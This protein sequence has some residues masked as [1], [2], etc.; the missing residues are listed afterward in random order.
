M[1]LFKGFIAKFT[2]ISNEIINN[3]N[4]SYGAKGLYMYLVSKPDGWNYY[5]D[6]MVKKS[7]NSRYKVQRY[8][9][10]LEQF[11]YL[12]RKPSNGEKGKLKGWD[13]FIYAEPNRQHEIPTTANTDDGKNRRTDI[14]TQSNT[15]NTNTKNDNNTNNIYI[16]EI[17]KIVNYLNDKSGKKYKHTTPK[18]QKCIRARLKEGFDFDDF[19]TVIDKKCKQWKDDPTMNRYLRPETLF[20]PKFEGYLNEEDTYETRRYSTYYQED[21]RKEK[22]RKIKDPASL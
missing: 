18:T 15:N 21:R 14:Q 6:D 12:E 9:K 13:Y 1:K 19:K 4:L 8:I 16:V 17:E 2:Q 11:G 3:E 7:N 22:L 5:I 10:E 20:S